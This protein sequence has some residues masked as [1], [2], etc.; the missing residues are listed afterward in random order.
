VEASVRAWPKRTAL[1]F[2]GSRWSYS[3]FWEATGRVAAALHRDGVRAGDRLALYLPNCPVHPIAFF[4]ALR[5]GATVVPVSPLSVGDD[6]VHLLRD[7]EPAGIVTLDIL[8]GNF[9]KV[10]GNVPV[11]RRYVAP[12]RDLYPFYLRPFV[13]AALRKRGYSTTVPTEPPF[14]GWGDMLRGPSE[15][16][17]PEA[18][19][20]TEVAVLQATGGTTG[21]P[22]EA[23]LTHRNLLAN[24]LQCQAWFQA[25]RPGTAVVLAS[26]P[27]THVYGMTVALNY[28]LVNGATIILELRPEAGE[29]LRLIA[30]HRP[31]ELPGVPTLYR[32]IADHPRVGRT[33]VR[34]IRVCISGS[35]PLPAEVARRFESITGGSLVEGYGLTEASPVTHANPIEP[36]YRRAG[37]IGLPFP[38]TDQKV[39]D[40]ETGRRTLSVGER[41]ELAVRGPQVM[42]GYYRN[43][44]ETEAVLRDGWLLT[45]DVATIDADGYA[46]IVD[47]KK[48]MIDVGGLKV[49]PRE[50]EEVLYRC[51]GVAEAAAIGVP[52]DALGEVVKAFVVPMPGATLS[53]AEV[54]AYVR[55]HIAHYKAPRRVEVRASLPK[56][57][58]QKVLRRT[59]RDEERGPDPRA[60]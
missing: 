54:I 45:G 33:N 13:N 35:A 28:P 23:M 15:F 60:A 9:A 48:D 27:L 2:N 39:V 53:E 42:W 46:F 50:V 4:G 47:R 58:I 31:T 1:V 43:P 19:P 17:R 14:Q 10:S 34:S 38:L 52:D 40:L 25:E 51:P 29:M 5:L 7:T 57:A 11:A 26:I 8:Y 18:D 22:K 32:A 12:L 37:S 41:G 44:E 6:L 24:A 20:S 30:K 59:L 56:S 49:Y 3:Q 36:A 21:T 16:P 55:E